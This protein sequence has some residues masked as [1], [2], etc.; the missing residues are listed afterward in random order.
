[1]P[2][3]PKRPI[4]SIPARSRTNAIGTHAGRA[5]SVLLV[6]AALAAPIGLRAF[7]LVEHSMAPGLRATCA[8]CSRM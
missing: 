7:L 2:E 4:L 1:M 8:V 5:R 6:F 3:Q